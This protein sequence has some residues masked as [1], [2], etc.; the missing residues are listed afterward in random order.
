MRISPK[1]DEIYGTFCYVVEPMVRPKKQNMIGQVKSGIAKP[2]AAQLYSILVNDIQSKVYAPGDRIPSE[3]ELA[4]QYGISRA[5]VRECIAHL[6]SEGILIRA[7]G[8][9]T[10]VSEHPARNSVRASSTHNIVFVAERRV[11][12]FFQHRYAEMLA[13]IEECLHKRNYHLVLRSANSGESHLVGET[14]VHDNKTTVDACIF[15]GKISRVNLY[16]IHKLGIPILL[17]DRGQ[18]PE[19]PGAVSIRAD[20]SNG[21][22]KAMQHLYEL[23]HREVGFIGIADSMKYNEYCKSLKVLGIPY[24]P[25]SVEFLD[26]FDLPPA[27]LA[28]HQA[29]QSILLNGRLPSSLLV[30]DDFVAVGVLEALSIAGIKVPEEISIICFDDLGQTS[31][32]PLTRLRYDRHRAGVT[33]AA[34][35]LA[36]LEGNPPLDKQILMPVEFIVGQS[37]AALAASHPSNLLVDAAPELSPENRN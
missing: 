31:C 26:L 30:T 12:N 22:R 24:L 13:G 35:I 3:R 1:Y 19:A 34:T 23:G 36:M 37:T 16:S 20:Y 11:L 28:G 32:P 15:G 25:E 21:T 5:S 10:F 17:I 6:I 14:L 27:I 9:G 33:A 7:G 4:K 29:V 8:R 18:S 2:V